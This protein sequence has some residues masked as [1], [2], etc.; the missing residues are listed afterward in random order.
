[1]SESYSRPTEPE[2]M[3][4]TLLER[5]NSGKVSAMMSSLFVGIG[6]ILKVPWPPIRS[7]GHSS[8]PDQPLAICSRP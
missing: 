5:F 1:M 3:V 4:A 8:P 7:S 6:L 2:G